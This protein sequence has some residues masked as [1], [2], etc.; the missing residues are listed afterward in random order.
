[1]G[2]DFDF[3]YRPP[4]H[5]EQAAASAHFDFRLLQLAYDSNNLNKNSRKPKAPGKMVGSDSEGTFQGLLAHGDCQINN[6][7]LHLLG[8]H[9]AANAALALA[10]VEVLRRSGWTITESAMR[11][12][13]LEV[14]W[15]AR[16][17]VVARRPAVVLDTAHNAASIAALVDVL[18]ESFSVR[19]R[20]LIFATTHEK[21]V[22][23]MLSQLLG[24]FD[25]VIFTKYQD[26]PR[27]VPP[28]Q[29]RDVA[30]EQTVNRGR[31]FLRL[32]GSAAD[33]EIAA[34]PAD[35]WNAACR[36]A[37][38]DDLICVTGSFFLAAEMRRQI[39]A[40]PFFASQVSNV[41]SR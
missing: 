3:D 11:K 28:E 17:E 12:G 20:L 39:A 31:D 35:A 36:L 37:G 25:H 1:L 5:L 33:I 21:D 18:M 10:V 13:L 30:A 34:T 19:R 26:N 29:L 27:G 40:R 16:V 38:P 22:R 41:E 32:A 23:G 2:V 8:R 14:A 6:I 15:P 24:R 4:R 7:A 9:Q